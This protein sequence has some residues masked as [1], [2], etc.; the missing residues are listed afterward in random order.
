MSYFNFKK[1]DTAFFFHS[2]IAAITLS[3][4]LF[5]NKMVDAHLEGGKHY[6]YFFNTFLSTLFICYFFKYFFGWGDVLLA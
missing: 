5:L 6:F 2:V 3:V 4:S 1:Y